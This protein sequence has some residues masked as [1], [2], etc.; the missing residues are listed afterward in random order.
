[1]TS[2]ILNEKNNKIQNIEA[3]RGSA[4]VIGNNRSFFFHFS[5][6]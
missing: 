4:I 1:M 3:L 6:F 2:G 5:S